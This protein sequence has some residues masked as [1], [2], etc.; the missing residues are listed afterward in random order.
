MKRI[1]GVE[2]SRIQGE[3]KIQNLKPLN[4]RNLV[5]ALAEP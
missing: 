3:R 5:H 4:P 1:Q 2:G